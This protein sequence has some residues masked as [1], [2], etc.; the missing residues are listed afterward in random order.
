MDDPLIGK[1]VLDFESIKENPN[2]ILATNNYGGHMAYYENWN[3][4]T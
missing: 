2:C 3:S 1:E 4:K